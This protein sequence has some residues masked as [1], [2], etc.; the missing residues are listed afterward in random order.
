MSA[1]T[2]SKIDWDDTRVVLSN[3]KGGS[4][5]IFGGEFCKIMTSASLAH[6][7]EKVI[8]FMTTK[9]LPFYTYH[10]WQWGESTLAYS[11]VD[12]DD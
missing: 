1:L 3:S 11:K 12:Q 9:F 8:V 2:S 7:C 5:V 6:F 4:C 10:A